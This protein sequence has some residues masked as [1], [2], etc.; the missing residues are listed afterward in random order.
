MKSAP[1]IN[2]D[3]GERGG[4]VADR[5]AIPPLADGD[6]R[7]TDMK[8]DIAVVIPAIT[9]DSW[10]EAGPVFV[11]HDS[12]KITALAA[13]REAG[14]RVMYK[15]GLHDCNAVPAK[16]YRD[17]INLK[18]YNLDENDEITEWVITVHP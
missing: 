14:Y 10:V 8:P 5:P 12:K 7:R 17:E 18:R 3:S 16:F 11:V 9:G 15:G 2:P 6:E 1:T 13:L 4:P